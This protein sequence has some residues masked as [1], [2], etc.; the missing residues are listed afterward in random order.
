MRDS[1]EAAPHR[2]QRLAFAGLLALCLTIP[3][4]WTQNVPVRYGGRHPGLTHS[5]WYP[6]IDWAPPPATGVRR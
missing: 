3:S 6:A 5:W 4:N 1:L 2:V